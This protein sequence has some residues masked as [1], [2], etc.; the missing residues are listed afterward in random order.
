MRNPKIR[1]SDCGEKI[2]L[3]EA[4]IISDNLT[5]DDEGMKG[6]PVWNDR[7]YCE[8]CYKRRTEG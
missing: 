7:R 5:F 3:S 8:K 6:I 2:D 4:K 1:C